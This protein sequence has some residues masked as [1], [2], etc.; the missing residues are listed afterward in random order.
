MDYKLSKAE[1]LILA[2]EVLIAI[3]C[4]VALIILGV[5]DMVNDHQIRDI[6]ARCKTVDG[7]MGYSKCYKNGREI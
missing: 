4:A 7:E 3:S 5:N 6:K 1:V 2:T